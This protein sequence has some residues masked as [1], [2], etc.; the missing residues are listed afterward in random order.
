MRR[1]GSG[2]YKLV[3]QSCLCLVL[4]DCRGI[5]KASKVPPEKLRPLDVVGEE[6]RTPRAGEGFRAEVF[7]EEVTVQPRDR[8]SISAWDVGV[9]AVAPGV[10]ESEALPFGSLYFWR[11]PDDETFL[12]A[13]VV[14]AF[15][16]IFIAKST[17]SLG[18]LEGILI[19]NSFTV[20]I[21]QAES[22]DGFRIEEEELLWGEIRPGVGFGGRWQLAEPAAN[23]NMFAISLLAEPGF[24]YF[25]GGADTAED[26][27]K[28][29]DTFEGRGHLRVRLDA[30]ERNL[31][32]LAHS[33]FAT[34]A[35]LI[36]GFRANWDDWG[37]G[38]REDASDTR[39]YV[40]FAGY[41]WGAGGVP[42]VKSER[43]RL[44]GSIHGGT[45]DDLD[46]FSK[47]RLGGGPSGDEYE[48]LSRPIIPGALIEE[49]KTSHYAVA[50][51]EYRWE[52]IFFSYLGLRAS[53]AYVDRDRFRG[54]EVKSRD[55]VIASIG[56]RLTTGFLFET[57]V[58]VDYNYNTDVLRQGDYGG[59]EIVAHIS[60]SF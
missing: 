47:F 15:N 53:V 44:V 11:H 57:R 26:F 42:A 38:G 13:V 30:I 7:G 23:D 58:Q 34:G 18:P 48:A 51:G 37:P 54:N 8:R 56:T 6:Y 24:L 16:D 20:P 28:P 59:H 10:S 1:V 5:E 25:D 41:L 40:S 43:H 50:A 12:R 33:G 52:P 39:D 19:F 31:L 22:V 21:D 35:D 55:D 49:Y 3:L 29:Q 2:I 45:G 27:V 60:G 9:S 36:Y 4:A 14:G 32:D 17:D 46:R